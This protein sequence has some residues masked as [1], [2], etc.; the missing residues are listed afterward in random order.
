MMMMM[1]MMDRKDFYSFSSRSMCVCFLVD[2]LRERGWERE[3]MDM[4]SSVCLW[5]R[6]RKKMHVIWLKK[7]VLSNMFRLFVLIHR[8]CLKK[9]LN[10][11]DLI[12]SSPQSRADDYF[13]FQE[14]PWSLVQFRLDVQLCLLWNVCTRGHIEY[15]CLSYFRRTLHH[16]AAFFAVRGFGCR[17]LVETYV[18]TR[19]GLHLSDLSETTFVIST[20][21]NGRGSVEVLGVGEGA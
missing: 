10:K 18:W 2:I 17:S 21:V 11:A 6:T 13:S 20:T 15:S 7:D 9:M 16:H 19:I 1:M 3:W 8:Q 12:W 14:I 5:E 4:R